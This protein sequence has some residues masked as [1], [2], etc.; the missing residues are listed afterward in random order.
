MELSGTVEELILFHV[1]RRRKSDDAFLMFSSFMFCS[2]TWRGKFR[3]LVA[4]KMLKYHTLRKLITFCLARTEVR[5]F[6]VLMVSLC[7][8]FRLYDWTGRSGAVI[9]GLVA[10]FV[11]QSHLLHQTENHFVQ[12]YGYK[13]N[14]FGILFCFFLYVATIGSKQNLSRLLHGQQGIL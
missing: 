10:L 11:S 9:S 6:E 13:V 4:D 5:R 12:R 3:T 2:Q 1:Y 7:L 8:S 14:H